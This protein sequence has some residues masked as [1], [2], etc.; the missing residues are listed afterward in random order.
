MNDTFNTSFGKSITALTILAFSHQQALHAHPI[1]LLPAQISSSTL[2]NL[3][4]KNAEIWDIVSHIFIL[5]AMVAILYFFF[6]FS[7]WG[8][9]KACKYWESI[10][11]TKLK[12]FKVYNYELFDTNLEVHF[13]KLLSNAIRWIMNIL[14]MFTAVPLVFSIFPKTQK[15]A[16]AIA[17]HVSHP[18]K[19]IALDIVDYIPNLI[20]ITIIYLSVHYII[21]TLRR[22]ATEIEQGRLVIKGFYSDWAKTTYNI[23]KYLL[24]VFMITLM[25]PYL[26]GANTGVF[27]GIS[28]FVG[29][30]VS[31][32]SSSVVGN[33][34]GGIVITYMRSFKIGDWINLNDKEGEVIE[35]TAL[36]TR[37][38]TRKNEIITMPNSSIMTTN[39]TNYTL[40][41]D[42]E[43]LIIHTSISISYNVPWQ[44]VHAL[45]IT[46][47]L[48]CEKTQKE[49]S[50]F[51]LET[52][53]SDSYP[54]YQINAYIKD[55]SNL[56]K[57]YSELHQQIQ[58]VFAKANVEILSPKYYSVRNG[59]N[60]TVPNQ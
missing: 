38:R 40:S 6:K 16:Y 35:R 8:Y 11:N 24:Y 57:M 39:A 47:A 49:P 26:P 42:N 13:L 51:V 1:S 23:I 48:Q 10:K 14:I 4:D 37:I 29:L 27:K 44:K 56:P 2:P 34:I 45:L 7:H 33:L 58:E 31:L 12:A 54:I 55:A 3:Q 19:K 60:S 18:I 5:A 21:K 53:L 15:I 20:T 32:G 36:V 59:N 25:Y 22:I 28:I 52:S 46:A 43:G 9:K 17:Q 41:T 50:P 30:L